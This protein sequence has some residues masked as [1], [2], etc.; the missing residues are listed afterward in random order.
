M[1]C[2]ELLS[3]ALDRPDSPEPQM[4]P[5]VGAAMFLDAS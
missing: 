4:I 5:T 2:G 3:S 1:I